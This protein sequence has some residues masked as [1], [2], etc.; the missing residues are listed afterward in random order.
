MTGVS[1]R[2]RGLLVDQ[3][4]ANNTVDR[5]L[6]REIVNLPLSDFLT[7]SVLPLQL[8]LTGAYFERQALIKKVSVGDRMASARPA[9]FRDRPGL[10]RSR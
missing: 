3:Q 4:V 2:D 6:D 10:F 7:S 8:Q 5:R 9:H 1:D